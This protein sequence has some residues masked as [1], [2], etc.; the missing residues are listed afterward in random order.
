MRDFDTRFGG[1][2]SAALNKHADDCAREAF[3]RTKGDAHRGGTCIKCN[4]SVRADFN[5]IGGSGQ[6]RP[7]D[8]YSPEGLKEYGI[9]GLCEYCWDNL[10]ADDEEDDNE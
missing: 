7:G 8:I 6:L 1:S 2:P 9:S 5:L 4:E 10:F 3:G